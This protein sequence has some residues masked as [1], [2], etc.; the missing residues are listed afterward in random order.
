MLSDAIIIGTIFLTLIPDC[1]SDKYD[2]INFASYH[3]GK[4]KFEV[5][6]NLDVLHI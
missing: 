4:F 3:L 2:F 1:G 6:I 5:Y